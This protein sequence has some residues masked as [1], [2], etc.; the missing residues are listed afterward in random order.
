MDR[1]VLNLRGS[2]PLPDP[3]EALAV[4][5][6][7]V[8][9][10]R[11][12]SSRAL[13]VHGLP[14]R[15]WVDLVPEQRGPLDFA[16]FAF[17]V[18]MY[19]DRSAHDRELVVM[20]STQVGVSTLM[21]RWVLFH[22]DVHGRNALYTFPTDRELGDFSRQRIRPV[23]RASEHL[24]SRIP[25]DGVDNVGQK[26]VG[27]GWVYFRGT[28][29]PVD[30]IDADVIVFDEYDTSDQASLEGT[31]RRVSG[32]LSA[33]LLR[34]VGVP[35]IPGFGIGKA[36]DESDQRVWTVRC[37]GCSTWNPMRGA[38]AFASNVDQDAMAM[39][40]RKCRRRLDVRVGEWVAAFPD[41][42]VRGYH[43]PRLIVPGVRLATIVASSR[44]TRPDQREAFYNR[45][46]GEPYAPAEGRLSFDQV[47][48][49]VD[50][51]LRPLRSLRSDR[52]VTMGVDVASVRG[53]NVVIEETLDEYRGRRVFVGEVEDD[54]VRGSAFDQLCAL[55]DAFGITMACIDHA[56]EGRFAQAFAAQFP[57]RVYLA[58][59]YSPQ[60]GQRT[61]NAW[62]VDDQERYVGLWRTRAIDA[63]LE[64]FRTR[65]VELPP[66]DLLP[67]DYPAQLG[68]LVRRN[69]EL[70]NGNIRVDYVRTGADDYA[71]AEV[72]NLAAIELAWRRVGLEMATEPLQLVAGDDY[73]DPDMPVYR[74]GF[75]D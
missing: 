57:G 59:Y 4:G 71:H 13:A 65:S 17:Q 69:V 8:L 15:Q 12:Q 6:D 42:E 44:K 26:Q 52:F 73:N 29:R 9:E 49:C 43:V 63:T 67:G 64:R 47:Q 48:A 46:L 51:Q 20:K 16:R 28:Q 39:V 74:P 11:G 41:R 75:E 31:E 7:D 2:D 24:M 37:E 22:A 18:E 45:D 58:G 38:E 40:C 10:E 61:P 60:P 27:Q 35:S 30:S 55:M 3:W 36:Y 25:S 53:L 1:D 70:P 5:L 62:H 34:R 19:D 32:P 68:A 66:L 54:P 50:E 14:F 56:P 72:Y 23:I 33:G 21:V